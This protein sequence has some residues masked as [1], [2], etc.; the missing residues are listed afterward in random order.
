MVIHSSKL[1]QVGWNEWCSLPELN[2]PFIKAKIDT[3]AKTSSLHA[4]DIQADTQKNIVQFTVHPVQ[5]DTKITIPCQATIVDTRNV[6]SS[7]GHIE[8]RY[9]IK[10]PIIL[11]EK[12]WKIEVTLSNRDPLQYRM[13]LGRE[14]LKKRVL[15]DP[16][17]DSLLCKI[18]KKDII[19][20]Y[21]LLGED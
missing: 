10:T 18:R 19:S 12:Q 6:M 3:G 7:N 20:T 11:G 4:F 16:Q 14:A 1:I 8:P 9:V 17:H 21:K 2:I 5:G 13:L 15:V